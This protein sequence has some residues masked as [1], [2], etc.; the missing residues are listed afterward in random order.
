MDMGHFSRGGNIEIILNLFTALS[1]LFI[2]KLLL[3]SW[4]L[5]QLRSDI[6]FQTERKPMEPNAV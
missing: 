4:D 2:C 3:R 1:V 6:I 5:L